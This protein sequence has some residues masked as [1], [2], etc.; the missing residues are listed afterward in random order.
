VVLRLCA[1][2]ERTR[3]PMKLWRGTWRIARSIAALVGSSSLIRESIDEPENA[4]KPPRA[5]AVALANS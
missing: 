3:R 2:I 5:I 1:S 4:P